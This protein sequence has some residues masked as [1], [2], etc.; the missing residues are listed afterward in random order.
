MRERAYVEAARV[1][2]ASEARILFV[3]VAPNI[4]PLSFLYG[5]VAIGW[6]ILTEAAVS[7]VGFGD[8]SRISWG[9]MLQDAFVSQALSRGSLA[10]VPAARHLHRARGRRRLLHLARRRGGAVPEAAG[11]DE[12]RSSRSMPSPSSTGPRA[13][14]CAP[15]TARAST[16]PEGAVVGLVGESGCGKTTVARAITGVMPSNARIAGGRLV[17]KGRDLAAAG[18]GR[19]QAGALAR[20][21]LRAAERHELA[22]SGLH[23]RAPA[24]GGAG[25][26]R[27]AT[28][29]M[30]AKRAR[31][32]AVPARR[33]EPAAARRVP[34]PVLRRHA[35][36]RRH[37]AGAGA[38]AQPR[39]RRRARHRARRH[40]AAPGARRHPRACR[41][42][43]SCR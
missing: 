7:F 31:G 14:A 4:L 38:R 34:A 23:G 33:P 30:A 28:P 2:G 21:L 32:G 19:A 18:R 9:F 17:F 25:P 36:A 16:V 15:S 24:R 1:T 37:R 10:L 39:H 42:A 3:H 43:C 12:W 35:P 27:R 41:R 40:R 26:S 13:A 8:P 29:R 11:A 22:R 20:H 5:S 6:A